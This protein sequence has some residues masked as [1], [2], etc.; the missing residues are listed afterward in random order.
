MLGSGFSNQAQEMTIALIA[1]ADA[2]IM[3]V[4]ATRA[5]SSLIPERVPP[6]LKQHQPNHR[7]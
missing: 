4:T 7:M 3:V 2:A 5:M 6:A 1:P